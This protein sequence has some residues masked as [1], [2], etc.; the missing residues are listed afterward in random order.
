LTDASSVQLA[1]WKLTERPR[2]RRRAALARR[3]AS[4][5]SASASSPSAFA[6]A[7]LP[8]LPPLSSSSSAPP[9]S[10]AGAFSSV[11]TWSML[12]MRLSDQ[13]FLLLIL[14][15]VESRITFVYLCAH[16]TGGNGQPCS[17]CVILTCDGR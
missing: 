9:S 4:S 12:S 14:F 3:A 5:R 7:A 15:S 17:S 1:F 6:R 13:L 8:G 16:E 2:R 11:M 10:S